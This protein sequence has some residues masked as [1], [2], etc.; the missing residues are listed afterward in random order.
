MS[1]SKNKQALISKAKLIEILIESPIYKVKSTENLVK[2]S[3]SKAKTMKSLLLSASTSRFRPPR[4][5]GE[6]P[7]DLAVARDPIHG[8]APDRRHDGRAVD[9][10]EADVLR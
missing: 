5:V 6:L 1:H 3:S 2:S 7:Q 8:L 9:A 4:L 10:H